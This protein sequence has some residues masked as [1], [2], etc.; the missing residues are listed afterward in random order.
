MAG[1]RLDRITLSTDHIV[2]GMAIPKVVA[3]KNPVFLPLISSCF[4]Q[5]SGRRPALCTGT[6]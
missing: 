5:R 6:A 3:E 2:V 1:G 4:P